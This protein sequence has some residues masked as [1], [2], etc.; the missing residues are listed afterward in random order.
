MANSKIEWTQKVWNPVTGCTKISAG[1]E[2]CYAEKFAKRLAGRCGYDQENPF[3]IT[4]HED[5]IYEPAK[6]R[7]PKIVFV[8]SMGD[9]FH[10]DVPDH[11][12]DAIM[13]TAAIFPKHT[14]MFLTKRP[15]R[16]QEYFS[17]SK[18]EI[19]KNWEDS[20]YQIGWAD[21]DGDVDSTACFLYNYSQKH[22]PIPNIWLGVTVENQ[23]TA[24]YRIPLLGETLAAKRFISVEPMLG[25][26]FIGGYLSGYDIKWVICGGEN[27]QGARPMH[28]DWVSSLLGQSHL[29][30]IPFFFKG[31]G[32]WLYYNN[33]SAHKLGKKKSGRMIDG[34]EYLQYPKFK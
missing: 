4:S 34:K 19:L 6:W 32:E 27:G 23:A 25:N 24:N 26:L 20:I 1:C 16:M 22:W 29:L 10:D 30:A 14:F 28:P 5:K 11:W 12:I 17:R 3:K 8:G 15:K 31:W 7:K 18:E 9:I 33:S 21:K 2:N 13:A